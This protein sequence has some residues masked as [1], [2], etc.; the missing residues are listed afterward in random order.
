MMGGKQA[1]PGRHTGSFAGCLHVGDAAIIVRMTALS[2][3]L[4]IGKYRQ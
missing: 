3:I 4:R 1:V 2:V